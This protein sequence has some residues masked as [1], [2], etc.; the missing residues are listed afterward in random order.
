[1]ALIFRSTLQWTCNPFWVK[2]WKGILRRIY[3]TSWD[4]GTFRPPKTHSSNAHAQP[5][6]GATCLMFGRTLR[7]LS[8]FMCANSEGSGETARIRR[9]ARA[10]DGCLCD[11][12]HYLMRWLVL[13]F[14]ETAYCSREVLKNTTYLTSTSAGVERT[15]AP[16]NNV[17]AK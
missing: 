7:L 16:H 17:C 13:K 5:S 1:M 14:S 6:S 12:Y 15:S 2:T 8:Y 4:Y 11:K 3:A 10:F 9:L